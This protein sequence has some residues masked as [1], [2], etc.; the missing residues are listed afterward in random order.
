MQEIKTDKLDA[1]AERFKAIDLKVQDPAVIAD[2][3]AWAELCRERSELEPIV[4]KYAE[5]KKAKSDFADASEM[6]KSDDAEFVL[7]AKEE[8]ERL[9]ERID[10][11]TD[12]L[13]ILLLPKDPNDGKNAGR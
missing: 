7:F 10:G 12:E 9:A 11:I 4:E 1:I 3:K 6:Q 5:L 8:C 2:N 13:K